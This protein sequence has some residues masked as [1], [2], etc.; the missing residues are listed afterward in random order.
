MAVSLLISIINIMAVVSQLNL[1]SKDLHIYT[2]KK[3]GRGGINAYCCITLS[4]RHI[5]ASSHTVMRMLPLRDNAVCLMGATHFGCVKVEH[6]ACE[7]SEM[8]RSHT[9][10]RPSWLP[11]ANTWKMYKY[12]N[13]V[14][15]L[16]NYIFVCA[17]LPPYTN[18]SKS[19]RKGRYLETVL[20]LVIIYF[21]L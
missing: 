1:G 8:S 3:G 12:I 10:V 13:T 21:L 17:H 20:L 5:V 19:T 11:T 15:G 2:K 4:Q 6:L 18:L 14:L 16:H 9:Y 7:G